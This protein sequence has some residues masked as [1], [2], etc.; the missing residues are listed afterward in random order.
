M[1]LSENKEAPFSRGPY[2]F[3]F[4]FGEFIKL[5]V[6][7]GKGRMKPGMDPEEIIA[8]MFK[9]QDR[10]HDGLITPDELKLKVEEDQEREAA[11]HTELWCVETDN[12][13]TNKCNKKTGKN[14]Q[15]KG[16]K[17]QSNRRFIRKNKQ[18]EDISERTSIQ[19]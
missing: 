6:A 4:Q 12:K 5:Q 13:H 17:E 1:R 18:T 11:Q 3:L 8:D 7:E 14:K 2:V 10:N 9:N 16:R 19:K 15:K